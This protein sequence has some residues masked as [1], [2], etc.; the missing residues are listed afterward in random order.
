[1]PRLL[2]NPQI[3]PCAFCNVIEGKNEQYNAPYH[4]YM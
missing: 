1:M 3:I 2:K 4:N